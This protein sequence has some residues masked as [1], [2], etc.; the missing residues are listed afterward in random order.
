MAGRARAGGLDPPDLRHA[1]ACTP[2]TR[3]CASR[4]RGP[5]PPSTTARCASCSTTRT[6]PS[7][8]PPRSR[9]AAAPGGR[10]DRRS[11]TDR[12]EVTAPLV[13]DALGLAPRAGHGRLPAPGRPALARPRGASRRT[14]RRAGDL[15]RPL[16]RAGRLRMELP[17]RA[18]RCGSGVGSFDPRFHV[19][20]PTVELAERLQPR[21]RPL[22]GQLDPAQA[23]RRPSRTTCSSPATPRAT[24]CR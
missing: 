10:A 2:R 21:R 23:A 17:G 20:E 1:G 16:D 4:C 6:T 13:V 14:Q 3:P 9:A 12:G 8:R 15:D 7:S 24:A 18:T 11:S 19:K 22:P 5:S